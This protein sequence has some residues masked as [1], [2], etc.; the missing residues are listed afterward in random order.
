MNSQQVRQQFLEFFEQKGHVIVPSAPIVNKDDPTLLFTNAGMNPF[1][2]IFTGKKPVQYPRIA[3]TQKCLRVSGKHNDLEEV[4]HDT[5]H[6]TMF[7]MLGN[8]SFGDYFRAEAIA[9]AW[10]LLTEVYKIDKSSLYVTCFA[11]DQDTPKDL[12]TFEEWKKWV[13]QEHILF[14]GKEAN[15]WEMG[16]TGPCGPCTEIHIDLRP[17]E[18]KHKVDGKTLINAGDPRV[19]EIWNIVLIQFDRKADGTLIPLTLKSIDTGMGLE[20]L[21][22][23][24]QN[25][26]STY[27]TDIFLPLRVFLEDHYNCR[28]D[29]TE[30]EAVAIRVIVDHIRAVAFAIADGQ[31]PGNT[32]AGYVIRRILRRAARYGF[33]HLNIHQPFLYRLVDVLVENMGQAFPE[34]V[35]QRGF[36]KQVIEQEEAGFIRKLEQGSQR[37]TAYIQNY[38]TQK[39]EALPVIEGDFAFE[40]YDTYGFPLDL[41]QLMAQEKG[42]TVDLEGFEKNMAL[43][44]ERSKKAAAQETSDWV[45]LIAG[46]DTQFLGYDNLQIPA[47]ITRYRSVKVK[48]TICYHLMLDQTPFYAESGGQVGDTGTLEN[49]TQQIKVLNTFKENESIIHQVDQLPLDPLGEWMAVVDVERRRKIKAN[50]SATHLLH[51]ALR[52]IL[53]THVEQRGSLVNDKYLR[54]DFSHFQ[55]LSPQELKQIEDLVNQ[56]IT[57]ALPLEVFN[58]IPLTEAKAMGAMALF[59]EKYAE[60]VRVIRFGADF[61]TE[62]CGGTHVTNTLEIRYFKILS[63]SAIAAGIRRIEAVTSDEALAYLE[64]QLEILQKLRNLLDCPQNIEKALIELIERN[65]SNEE[66]LARYQQQYITELRNKLLASRKTG[67]GFQWVVEQIEIDSAEAL[68]NLSFELKKQSEDSIFILGTVLD[69]KPLLSIMMSDSLTSRFNAAQ[70]IKTICPNIKGGGGGQPFYATAGGKDPAGL[71]LALHEAQKLILSN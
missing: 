10:E 4:G 1:K 30:I 21:C 17:E 31:L 43:Q 40:L 62:L 37:F 24:L 23:V 9:W 55:K 27:D 5:Y 60:K 6:H 47:R 33:Q 57:A 35:T 48:G 28:Y 12:E 3:N 53:G 16:D 64:S 63:E 67:N 15:F 32:G 25:K 45:E 14:F 2:D 36:I 8:W 41:T 34:L 50:H 29:R 46:T 26:T 52:K 65:K 58:N 11:G 59:G 7:E 54:F 68:K 13:P 20:R 39:K 71:P 66:K 42:F 61:S 69:G 22:M 18:E 51:A 38:L 49:G 19:I 70:I 44:K 56:K